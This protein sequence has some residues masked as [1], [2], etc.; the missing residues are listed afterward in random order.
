MFPEVADSESLLY[1]LIAIEQVAPEIDQLRILR[2]TTDVEEGVGRTPGHD[3]H[4]A[5]AVVPE[6]VDLAGDA[7]EPDWVV[8]VLEEVM[9]QDDKPHDPSHR[10]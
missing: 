1:L 5:G 9:P 10:K 6:E 3:S 8:G 7:I 2:A 4:A